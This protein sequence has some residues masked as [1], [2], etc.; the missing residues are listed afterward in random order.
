MGPLI[1][2]RESPSEWANAAE[3]AVEWTIATKEATTPPP[4]YPLIPS[5]GKIFRTKSWHETNQRRNLDVNNQ[6]AFEDVWP[7]SGWF[8]RTGVVML[9]QGGYDALRRRGWPDIES[10]ICWN[11][12]WHCLRDYTEQVALLRKE[13]FQ[14]LHDGRTMSGGRVRLKECSP[15][16]GSTWRFES[17]WIRLLQRR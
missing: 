8:E 13:V 2:C 11:C 7:G 14:I 12:D 3:A 4:S 9:M 15:R 6:T 16:F 1:C 10:P 17:A 5:F